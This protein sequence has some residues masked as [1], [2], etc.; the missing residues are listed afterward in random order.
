MMV[1]GRPYRARPDAGAA[2]K[3]HLLELIARHD[4]TVGLARRVS[5]PVGELGGYQLTADITASRLGPEAVTRIED[6]PVDP[7]LL[8]R[9][10]LTA[11][12]PVGLI[13][14][15]EHRVQTLDAVARDLAADAA[16]LHAEA[17][18]AAAR[19]GLPFD[20]T[21]QPV[22][23]AVPAGPNRPAAHPRRRRD[24]HPTNRL[25]RPLHRATHAGGHHRAGHHGAGHP[26]PPTG[27]PGPPQAAVHRT[28]N[29]A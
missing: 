6:L 26:P 11:A 14:R 7:I 22:G 12:A 25:R 9:G 10:E 27:R 16:R 3:A 23:S 20:H 29:P 2:L 28:H 24:P 1:A 15:F 13:A 21:A 19:I 8:D 4:T 5:Y 18:A 17:D